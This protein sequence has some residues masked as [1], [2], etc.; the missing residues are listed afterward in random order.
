MTGFA[1][2]ERRCPTSCRP[3]LRLAP[4]GIALSAEGAIAGSRGGCIATWAA[5]AAASRAGA[6]SRTTR[7]RSWRAFSNFSVTVI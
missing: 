5:P 6:I 4:C 3:I 7:P 1:I 2:A